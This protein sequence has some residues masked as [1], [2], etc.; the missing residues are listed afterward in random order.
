MGNVILI[1][2]RR[3]RLVINGDADKRADLAG[4][5]W[6]LGVLLMRMR[7]VHGDDAT[8]SALLSVANQIWP[9]T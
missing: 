6:Q 8:Q 2:G 5:R 9:E 1:G 4:A 3:P 7:A